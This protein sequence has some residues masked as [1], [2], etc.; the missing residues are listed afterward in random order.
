MDQSAVNR[1]NQPPIKQHMLGCMLEVPQIPLLTYYITS[2]WTSIR[3]I[4][5]VELELRGSSDPYVS[6][7]LSGD[8]H[9]PCLCPCEPRGPEVPTLDGKQRN[10]LDFTSQLL[11]SPNSENHGFSLVIS[12][13]NSIGHRLLYAACTLVV[14]ASGILYLGG[15]VSYR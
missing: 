4:P 8:H 1:T 6:T 14:L 2:N 10:R 5:D 11:P 13:Q 7:Q 12:V 15:A 9:T 3:G